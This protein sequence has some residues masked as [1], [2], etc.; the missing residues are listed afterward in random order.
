MEVGPYPRF[1]QFVGTNRDVKRLRRLWYARLEKKGFKDVEVLL[2]SGELADR[3][4]E[5][6]KVRRQRHPLIMGETQSFYRMA[7]WFLHDHKFECARDRRIWERFCEGDTLRT[8]AADRFVKLSHQ[9]VHKRV[10]KLITGPFADYRKR[11][12]AIMEAETSE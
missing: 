11:V 1:N 10:M 9:A 3:M 12:A 5:T 2:P 8:I 7:A 4:V 6:F